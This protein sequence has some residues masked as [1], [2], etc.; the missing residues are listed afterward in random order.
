MLSPA[1]SEAQAALAQPPSSSASSTAQ[2]PA[3]DYWDAVAEY[4]PSAL[5]AGE[6]G[7]EEEDPAGWASEHLL[8]F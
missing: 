6:E 4:E 2:Q 1:P 7:G 5:L 3:R 8:R